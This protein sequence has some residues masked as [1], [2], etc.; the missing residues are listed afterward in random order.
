MGYMLGIA[1]CYVCRK[2][3]SFN[4]HLVPSYQG[5]PICRDCME[6]VNAVRKE[7]GLTPHPI[8]E[9]AY[10]PAEE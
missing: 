8:P 9:D 4:P 5:E 7:R 3:F 2:T 10:E 1:S 6:L